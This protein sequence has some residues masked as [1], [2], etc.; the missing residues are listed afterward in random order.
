M[1]IPQGWYVDNQTGMLEQHPDQP[2]NHCEH[3]IRLK[4]NL[5]GCKQAACNWFKYLSS[6]LIAEGICQSSTDPC[7]FLW[8]DCILIVYMDDCVIFA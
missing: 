4:C 3:Y 7:L 5:Y 1:R 6:G 8:H 2:Y